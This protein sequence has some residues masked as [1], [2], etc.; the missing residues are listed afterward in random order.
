MPFQTG[1]VAQ[2]NDLLDTF[3]TFLTAHGW[4]VLQNYK[5]PITYQQAETALDPPPGTE[6]LYMWRT[7]RNLVVTKGTVTIIMEDFWMT[8]ARVYGNFSGGWGP[9]I[10]ATVI[11]AAGSG[12]GFFDA[13]FPDFHSYDTSGPA[14]FGPTDLGGAQAPR[15][16]NGARQKTVIMP[17]PSMVTQATGTWKASTHIMSP[18]GVTNFPGNFGV[19]GGAA[20]PATYWMMCDATG[21]NVV[22]VVLRDRGDLD[23]IRQTPYLFFG[24][25]IK[26]GGAWTGGQYLG[27]SHGNDTVWT[28]N[29][30]PVEYTA[31][32]TVRFGPPGSMMDGAESHMFV[33][34][35]VDSFTGA[36]KWLG[37]CNTADGNVTTGRNM[38]STTVMI[39]KAPD[40]GGAAGITPNTI[41]LGTMRGRLSTLGS[42]AP[43]FPTYLVVQR[44]NG[45]YSI[46][47]ALPHIFQANTAG[48][49]PGFEWTDK[50][51]QAFMIFDGFAVR[52]DA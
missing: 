7:A 5:R 48:I 49:A 2:V 20:V 39:P 9:G 15:S 50:S 31:F 12:P 11:D 6:P 24:T 45:L 21:D 44:D 16:V 41:H 17:L 8:A 18:A 3:A 42:G 4:T 27:A 37:L 1:T 19:P 30:T 47:G 51:G 35:N 26:K 28:N 32:R 46:L 25:S 29:S 33:R 52:K 40:V 34:A 43:M 38:S 13:D 23:S 36:G 14:F 10:A 22:L